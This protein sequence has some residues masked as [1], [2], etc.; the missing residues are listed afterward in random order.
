MKR[1]FSTKPENMKE[2]W[3]GEL[4][5]FSWMDF[6]T[7]IPLPLF[8][9]TGYKSNNQPNATMQSWA[10]FVS[11]AGEFVCVLGSANKFGH[12]YHSLKE[13]GCCVLNFYSS[14][15]NKQ[16]HG[17][18]E[19]N[20]FA[21]DEITSAGLTVEKAVV[22]NAPRIVECFLNMECEFLWEKPCFEHSDNTVVA[23]KVVHIAMNSDQY[24]GLGRY[25]KTGYC[26][27]INM[28]RSPD[29]GEVVGGEIATLELHKE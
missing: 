26:Y 11:D 23:L 27:N 9:V 15:L 19:N 2:E 5:M 8:V 17:T 20:Q 21:V 16:M 10:S 4:S 14:D 18:I 12:M 1:E 22:V 6:V 28:P 13:T 29:S 7:G 24:N 3:P 25:G